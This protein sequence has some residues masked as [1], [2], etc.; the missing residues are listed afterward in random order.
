MPH[1]ETDHVLAELEDTI[2]T[3]QTEKRSANRRRQSATITDE[4]GG[5][6]EIPDPGE[7]VGS[8][9]LSVPHSGFRG[10]RPVSRRSDGSPPPQSSAGMTVTTPSDTDPGRLEPGTEYDVDVTV[11]NA[12]TFSSANATVELFVEHYA[13]TATVDTA[14][15]A[16]ELARDTGQTLTGFTTLPGGARIFGVGYERGARTLDSDTIQF[17][18]SWLVDDDRTFSIDGDLTDAPEG[19]YT[20][21][22]YDATGM[23]PEKSVWGTLVGADALGDT[24][25]DG[26]EDVILD[27]YPVIGEVD[28]VFTSVPFND[29]KDMNLPSLLSTASFVDH[30]S[31]EFQPLSDA[32]VTFSYTT[33]ATRGNRVLAAFYARTYSRMPE[34]LPASMNRLDHTRSRFVGRTER[35]WER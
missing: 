21:R 6:A 13:P 14:D 35:S 12:G 31:V 20:L 3:L 15:G 18:G 2:R 9:E 26:Y 7:F 25:L 28:G 27:G 24:R 19:D 23:P 1:D 30:R 17:A 33:P 34:D 22:L 8:L 16:V 10:D 4:Y 29:T 5:R 11:G 32:T